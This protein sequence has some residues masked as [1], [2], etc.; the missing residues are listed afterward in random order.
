MA[1]VVSVGGTAVTVIVFVA[2]TLPDAAVIIA[3]ATVTPVTSP[4]AFTVAIPV[5]DEDQVT[6]AVNAFPAWSF[7]DAVS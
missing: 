2:V 4:A 7:G 1:I 5:A 6:A 3:L